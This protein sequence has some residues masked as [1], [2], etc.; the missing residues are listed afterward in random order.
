[1]GKGLFVLFSSVLVFSTLF[2]GGVHAYA[3]TCSFLAVLG[4][5]LCLL[6]SLTEREPEIGQRVLRIPANS[7]IALFLVMVFWIILQMTPLP[8]PL[9]E[10]VSPESLVAGRMKIPASE[11]VALGPGTDHWVALAPYVHPVRQALVRWTVYGLF[12]LCMTCLLSSKKRVDAL[13][14]VLLALGCFESLYGLS[15]TLGGEANVWWYPLPSSDSGL[16]GTFINRN[17]FAAFSGI[18]LILAAA[19]AASVSTAAGRGCLPESTR[20]RARLSRI[21]QA[22]PQ[23][24]KRFALLMC[25]SLSGIGLLM[26]G[27]KGGILSAAAG[28][29]A[30]GG[31]LLLRKGLRRRSVVLFILFVLIGFYAMGT[32]VGTTEARF[33]RFGIGL[34]ERMKITRSVLDMWSDYQWTGVG[35]GGFQH[36][37]PRY[38]PGKDVKGFF[39]YGHNDWAQFLAEAGIAGVGLLL[40]GLSAFFY[41]MLRRWRRRRSPFPVC[42]GAGAAAVVFATA[43]HS[44]G[45]FSL[46]I[47]AFTFSLLSALCL[48]YASVH[49]ETRRR[50]QTRSLRDR[51][52]PWVP[53]GR[54]VAIILGVFV[55]VNGVW[56][57]RH[58]VA[59]IY[60][61]TVPNNTLNRDPLP[62]PT[63]I[64]KALMWDGSNAEYWY[65]LARALILKRDEAV[66][67]GGGQAPELQ[68]EVIHALEEA[69]RRNPLNAR[70]HLRMGWECAHLWNRPKYH[71]L[72]LPAADLSM[73]RAAY[74]AGDKHPHLHQEM[75]NYWTMR[76]KTLY[77]SEQTHHAAWAR[78]CWHY[79]QAQLRLEGK[80]LRQV[81][82]E[83]RDFVCRFYPDET[84]LTEAVRE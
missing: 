74:Y 73:E 44:L 79:G 65:K 18:L 13:L 64:R 23:Y 66:Q 19:G 17:H 25:G 29:L 8:Q 56:V 21:L 71:T 32:G 67:A 84:Y 22:E 33:R 41:P 7:G 38:Q 63:E 16:S 50:G 75:G 59:E 61:N 35:I 39:R 60:C 11:A 4:G 53:L 62:E 31:M 45:E 70:Y 5:S 81:K 1:M 34:D 80:A 55:A 58:F 12:F 69:I 82:E 83:I 57:V 49:L 30:L 24:G 47:P 2:F 78:A 43:V 54:V 15:Q 48:G 6:W 28:L 36:A 42:M 10:M 27:S 20:W 14:F 46:H 68:D 76:S 72:W 51:R 9:V 52:I 37:Y 77:P 3:Y 40:V 26:S